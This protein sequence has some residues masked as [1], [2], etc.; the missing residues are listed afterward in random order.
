MKMKELPMMMIIL[1]LVRNKVLLDRI[2][3]R[4]I[5]WALL[6]ARKRL[7]EKEVT[8]CQ[9][10]S[11]HLLWDPGKMNKYTTQVI[12]SNKY[13]I[14]HQQHRVRFKMSEK[15]SGLAFLVDLQAQILVMLEEKLA[16]VIQIDTKRLKKEW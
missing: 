3:F 6:W 2:N 7:L 13:M 8:S 12:T 16:K 5:F 4:L 11:N 1:F 14:K 15:L 10:A 9:K